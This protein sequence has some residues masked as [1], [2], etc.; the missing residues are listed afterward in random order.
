MSIITVKCP[1]CGE[2]IAS[3]VVTTP[4]VPDSKRFE[5]LSCHSILKANQTSSLRKAIIFGII[6]YVIVTVLLNIFSW[7]REIEL[8]IATAGIFIPLFISFLVYRFSLKIEK[9][10]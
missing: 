4:N 7:S 3:W 5:C 8:I 1:A 10:Y 6:F 2:P 9:Y